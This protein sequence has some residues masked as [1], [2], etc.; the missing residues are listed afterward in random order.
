MS[1]AALLA[2]SL[3]LFGAGLSFA[4][5]TSNSAAEKATNTDESAKMGKDD[6]THTGQQ[7][8]KPENDTA[9]IEQP[10]RQN[11]TTSN[12]SQH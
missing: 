12:E 2:I 9:K 3:M 6:G 10:A 1:K 11:P 7:G 8:T 4:G 5:D